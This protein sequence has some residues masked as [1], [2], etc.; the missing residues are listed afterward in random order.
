[1]AGSFSMSQMQA[2]QWTD[3]RKSSVEQMGG[4]S[5]IRNSKFEIGDFKEAKDEEEEEEE[6]GGGTG[7]RGD[8]ARVVT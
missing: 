5:G 1:M 6:K 7:G 3:S 8:G 2:A 4:E